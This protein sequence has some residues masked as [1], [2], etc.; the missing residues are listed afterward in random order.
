MRHKLR[1]SRNDAAGRQCISYFKE[2]ESVQII[3]FDPEVIEV[4]EVDTDIGLLH[5]HWLRLGGPPPVR[6]F[7]PLGENIMC[8]VVDES[9][10]NDFMLVSANEGQPELFSVRTLKDDL[11]L[12]YARALI[13]L[14]MVK[15]T[16]QPL[17]QEV[18][19]RAGDAE[20][21]FRRAM[22]PA[23]N[24]GGAVERIYSTTR[25]VGIVEAQYPIRWAG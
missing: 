5:G 24:D 12:I 18:I 9:D 8:A 20:L 3:D 7:A 22:L 23:V 25:R 14:T 16:R 17:Y 6:A 11:P 1:S 13:D 15:E 4:W 19:H 10:P 21:A 2:D